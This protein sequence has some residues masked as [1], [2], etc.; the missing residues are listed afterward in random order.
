M[1]SSRINETLFSSLA[2]ARVRINPW[3][4]DNNSHRPHFSLGNFTPNE[5]AKKL[6]LEKQAA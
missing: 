2:E 6:V 1:R 3:K 4:G 5:F